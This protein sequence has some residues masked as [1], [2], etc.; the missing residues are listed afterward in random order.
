[1]M[2]R[3]AMLQGLSNVEGGRAALPFVSMFYGAPSQYL[4]EDDSGTVHTIDQGE[5]GEQEMR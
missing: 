3:K 1:M 2:S 5:G 4:R